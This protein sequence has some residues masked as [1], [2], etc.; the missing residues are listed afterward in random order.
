[1]NNIKL[2]LNMDFVLV[3]LSMS[4]TQCCINYLSNYDTTVTA[5]YF[6]ECYLEIMVVKV[7][8]I[9]FFRRSTLETPHGK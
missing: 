1:M 9:S 8:F 6:K 4:M 2:V 5:K 3:L 7:S